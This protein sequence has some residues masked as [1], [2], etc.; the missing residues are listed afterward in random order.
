M[1][2]LFG[3][4]GIRGKAN[5]FPVLPEVILKVGKALGFIL[6]KKSQKNQKH[7]TVLIGK[8][9][10]LSGYMLEQ[11]MASGLN[12]AGIWVQLTG[13]L[14]T[15]GIG[16]LAHNMRASA[17]V[18]IS[19]SHNLYED[20]GIKI[21]GADGR[22]ISDEMQNQI[23]ELVFSENIENIQTS[24]VGRTRRIEDASGRYIVFVKR[25]FPHHL[26]LDGL[27]I[28]L[29]CANGAA[30]R[31]APAVFEEL[32]AEVLVI[33]NKPNGYNINKECGALFPSKIK[34]A[35]LENKA[36]L[37]ISLDGDADRVI[38]ADETGFVL[39]GDYI[40]GLSAL[41]LKKT[42]SI[43]QVVSTYTANTGLEK[44]LNNSGIDLIRV[45]HGDRNVMKCMKSNNIIL[46]GE[47]SGHI[48]FSE[49]SPTGDGCIAAL[50]VLAVMVSEKKKLSQLIR[51][52]PNVPQVFEKTPIKNKIP[53]E[54]ISGYSSMVF[55]LKGMLGEGG[56]FHIHFSGTEPVARIM[57][58]GESLEVIKKC[59]QEISEFL[60][61]HLN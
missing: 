60:K 31:V 2:K 17:G 42:H 18:I 54:S 20:N 29:D 23:E 36:D 24:E 38:I 30:Y 12:S 45:K 57:V 13:P 10:R 61:T 37:G 4:D 8:D 22:K 26:S 39:D 55:R 6:N 34:Q 32:G 7:H 19:A 44:L 41:H 50:N 1:K 47:P 49:H 35:V 16:F 11:A 21:F 53:L 25:T 27:K 33:G 46:G 5:Q 3:T 43:K 14:P 56:R 28:V 59:S 15:P 51:D 58:E 9:T 52:F 40:L 48:I